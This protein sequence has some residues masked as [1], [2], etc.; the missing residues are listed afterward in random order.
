MRFS[1]A[2][3]I[4]VATFG[5]SGCLFGPKMA[6]PVQT[7]AK[8]A[9]V[10]HSVQ[11]TVEARDP[12]PEVSRYVQAGDGQQAPRLASKVVININTYV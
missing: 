2:L 12:T 3:A 7:P 1:A 9:D 10:R 8:P 4:A 5:L 11:F 6:P